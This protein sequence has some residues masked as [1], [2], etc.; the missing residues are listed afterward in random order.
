RR[1]DH[2]FSNSARALARAEDHGVRRRRFFSRLLRIQG[3]QLRRRPAR[4]PNP[5]SASASLSLRH[6]KRSID[7]GLLEDVRA[8]R[9]EGLDAREILTWAIKNLHP[10]LALSCS[11]GNAEGL[12]LLDMMHRIE[13]TSRVYVLDTGRLHQPTY[14]LIDRVR[15][16][17]GKNVEVVFPEAAA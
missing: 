5:M 2:H 11:F 12:V 6:E 9:L 10:R 13:P 17:Y 8:G 1:N 7:S 4:S 3:F 14:D 15:D 16:R